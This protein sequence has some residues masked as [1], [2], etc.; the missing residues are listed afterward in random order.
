[1]IKRHL[2]ASL[3]HMQ[4]HNADVDSVFDVSVTLN[5]VLRSGRQ[6]GMRS[7][8]NDRFHTYSVFFG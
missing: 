1:M 4:N 5:V 7:D 2:N 3:Q 8:N 6:S